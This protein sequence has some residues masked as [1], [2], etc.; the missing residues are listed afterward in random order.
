MFFSSVNLIY[1]ELQG[2]KKNIVVLTGTGISA[3]SGIPTFRDSGGLWEKYDVYELA[4]PAAAL[5]N[6][7]PDN[8]EKFMIDKK[9]PA[10][11]DYL[12]F[13]RIEDSA[14]KGVPM[15]VNKLLN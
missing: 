6:F 13:T 11:A 10:I 1:T 2:E 8:A 15:V 9:I 7:I 14:V 12:H 3:E 4:S 5:I